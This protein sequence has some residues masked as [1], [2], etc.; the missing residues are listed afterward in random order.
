MSLVSMY[1]NY[2]FGEHIK[3]NKN[4]SQMRMIF[5]IFTSYDYDAS[6]DN[7]YIIPLNY[8]VNYF[9]YYD[10]YDEHVTLLLF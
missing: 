2:S 1:T 5:I 3:N 8:L 7:H 10:L 6:N 4:H 9:I